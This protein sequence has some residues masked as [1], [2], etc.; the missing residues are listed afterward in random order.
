MHLRG[1]AAPGLILA[2]VATASFAGPC[3]AQPACPSPG[4]RIGRITIDRRPVFD[5]PP[6]DTSLS[7]RLGAIANP[8]HVRT[9]EHVIREELLFREGEACRDEALAQSERNLRARGLF[10]TVAITAARREGDL[11]DVHVAAQDAWT[12]RLSG[13]LAR[14]GDVLVWELGL[15][16]TNV[17][18]EGFGTGLR[19]RQD[20]DANVSSAW[21]QHDR[22][23]GTRERLSLSVDNRSD[24]EAW[25][26]GLARPFFAIDSRWSHE[27]SA[28]RLRDHWRLYD[29]GEMTDE[30]ARD[31][32]GVTLRVAR[33]VGPVQ[34]DRAWRVGGG[35]RYT[36]AEFATLG[37]AGAAPAGGEMPPS[38]RFGGPFASVQ[39]LEHRFV[40]RTGLI[41][42]SRDL[43]LN[44]G[45]QINASGWVSIRSASL[46]TESRALVG[47]SV[48]RGWTAGPRSVVTA[49]A[50]VN[51]RTG[52]ADPADADA[53]GALRAWWAHS[54]VH[55]TAVALD[56]RS[57]VNP[58]PGYRLYLGGSTGLAGYREFTAY[59]TRTATLQVEERRYFPWK[60]AGL[61]QFGLAAFAGAGALGGRVSPSLGGRFLADAGFGLRIALLKSPANTAARLDLAF[62]LTTPVDGSRRPLLVV[63]YQRSF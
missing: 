63:G 9:R 44:L 47:A 27:L 46:D 22:L 25:A 59:A 37:P 13:E 38:H 33:R 57:L 53:T 14:I 61:V 29:A 39:F 23:F 11:A 45:W 52:G 5:T 15:S 56:A 1:P 12:L 8:L 18:G 30:F 34:Q 10:Q 58:E 6:G 41:V 62:P 43:D 35:Y 7:A 50:G 31:A 4:L 19:Y 17:A 40:K 55:V 54:A 51:V 3:A 20:I 48:S 32:A 21:V 49:T 24:G 60:P 26:A 42:P 36:A 2:V 16:D 28:S